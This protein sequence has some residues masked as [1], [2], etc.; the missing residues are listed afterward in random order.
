[1]ITFTTDIGRRLLEFNDA[2]DRRP[3]LANAVDEPS[4]EQN[5][6]AYNKLLVE[7]E[8]ADA[9]R[10]KELICDWRSPLGKHLRHYADCCEQL[11]HESRDDAF[12]RVFR[13]LL[14]IAQE[15]PGEDAG[16]AYGHSG[17][18]SDN[19]EEY[20]EITV[21]AGRNDDVRELI[22]D[23]EP[24]WD[25]NL[26]YGQ[27]GAAAYKSGDSSIRS[28]GMTAPLVVDGAMTGEV[29]LA[30]VEQQL[31]PTL[32]PGDTVILDNLSSHKQA[33]VREAI[34][35]AGA[36]LVYLP[37]YS[38]D[39]NP[40]ELAFAKLKALLRKAA[41]RGIEELDEAIAKL[42]ERFTIKECLAYFRYCGYSA[43]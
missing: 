31:V 41:A 25:H 24:H 10:L 32:R 9:A 15:I 2:P 21:K 7:C 3:Y 40:I 6:A 12:A 11:G 18:V 27:L 4:P 26:G 19:F 20:V 17:P 5:V 38:P 35:A 42:L 28:T 14:A 34:E 13:K 30:Y 39:L 23:L 43:R 8:T 36:R 33:G 37:P 29:F 16:D 1:M 22:Q